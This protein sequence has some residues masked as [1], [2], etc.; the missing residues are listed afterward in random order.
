IFTI[1]SESPRDSLHFRAMQ[2]A[3]RTTQYGTWLGDGD[4]VWA[5]VTGSYESSLPGRLWSGLD[6]RQL[7]LSP[8]AAYLKGL[9]P[10]ERFGKFVLRRPQGMELER[11]SQRQPW[12]AWKLE[13]EVP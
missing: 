4:L 7:D 3:V 11:P 1:F 9:G 5:H 2:A 8:E 10:E 12:L 13:K 6:T